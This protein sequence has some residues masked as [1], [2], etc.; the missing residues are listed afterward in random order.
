MSAQQRMRRDVAALTRIP[1][2]KLKS[3]QMTAAEFDEAMAAVERLR[4]IP[5]ITADDPGVQ[6]QQVKAAINQAMRK[7][8]HL[9]LIE[10]DY[11]QRLEADKGAVKS[12]GS[13]AE[14]L[15]QISR[16][17]HT[18]IK[19]KRV[20]VPLVG[21]AQV[22]SKSIDTRQNKRPQVSDVFG[23]SGLMKDAT[24]MAYIYRD[25]YYNP[26]TTLRPNIAEIDVKLH[27]DGPT[28]VV[29]LYWHGPTASF[30]NLQ[31]QEIQL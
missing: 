9:D 1:I 17:I 24:L 14:K 10:L 28:G 6:P 16:A 23:S 12:G 11:W 31:R 26:D 30:R 20:N 3:R 7:F 18:I 21:S 2:E 5:L 27:R 15:E 19:D 25:D 13:Q 22:V 8:G 4:K 29:D